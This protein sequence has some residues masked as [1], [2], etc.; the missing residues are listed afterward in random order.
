M[1]PRDRL[2]PQVPHALQHALALWDPHPLHSRCLERQL[3][4]KVRIVVRLASLRWTVTVSVAAGSQE[5]VEGLSVLVR[6]DELVRS[7]FACA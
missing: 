2:L 6:A 3:A 5:S 7:D 1:T 4:R